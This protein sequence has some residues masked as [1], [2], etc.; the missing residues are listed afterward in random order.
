MHCDDVRENH[1]LLIAQSVLQRRNDDIDLSLDIFVTDVSSDVCFGADIHC[2]DAN[3]GAYSTAQLSSSYNMSSHCSRC[4]E[5]REEF[6]DRS[7][8]FYIMQSFCCPILDRWKRTLA[9]AQRSHHRKGTA[10]LWKCALEKGNGA[11]LHQNSSQWK[12]RFTSKKHFDV[13]WQP[14]C[15]FS[16]YSLLHILSIR[17]AVKHSSNH[18]LLEL[19][20]SCVHETAR[21]K[22]MEQRNS[23]IFWHDDL[24]VPDATYKKVADFLL[25]HS[26]RIAI[27]LKVTAYVSYVVQNVL[28]TSVFLF[29]DGWQD[30]MILSSFHCLS[31]ILSEIIFKAFFMNQ[32]GFCD[33]ALLVE[34]LLKL[35][36]APL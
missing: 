23:N 15:V 11:M 28:E 3:A 27:M 10:I 34:I 6:G 30:Q 7:S 24:D 4:L 18:K 5:A 2:N 25:I 22:E 36:A 29:V 8:R 20:V 12:V 14:V 1:R 31:G 17:D 32:N 13:L 16:S 19:Y 26:D 35:M 33:T 9:T 21:R